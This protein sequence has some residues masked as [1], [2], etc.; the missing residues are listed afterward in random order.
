MCNNKLSLW[1]L[2]LILLLETSCSQEKNES[3]IPTLVWGKSVFYD[4]FLWDKYTPDTLTRLLVFD[5]NQD[6]KLFMDGPLTLALVKKQDDN[7]YVAITENEAHL[8][9]DGQRCVDNLILIDKDK[10]QA[11]LG[12]VF[13]RQIK[14]GQYFWYLK[15]VDSGGLDRINELETNGSDLLIQEI[16]VT[17]DKHWNPLAFWCCVIAGSLI[18][19]LVLWLLVFRP[20]FYPTFKVGKIL[21]RDPVPYMSSHRLSG[22]RALILTSTPVKQGFFSRVFTNRIQY[23]INPLWVSDVIITPRDKKSVRIK[24]SNDYMI[25]SRILEKGKEYKLRQLKNQTTT[26]ITTL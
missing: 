8:F 26:T 9:L 24:V 19:L 23:D 10:K 17:R 20:I 21:L 1:A 14:E 7:N 15:I 4:N 18:A 16:Q 13:N 5:F 22:K 11:A 2:L 25:D 3:E 12:I 6:A